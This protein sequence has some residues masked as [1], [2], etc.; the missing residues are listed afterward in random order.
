MRAAILVAVLATTPVA[1]STLLF[2][3]LTEGTWQV[4]EAD[5]AAG[6]A[7][8][9]TVTPGDKRSPAR[10][11]DGRLVFTNSNQ[12]AFMRDAKDGS[13]V[14]LLPALWPLRDLVPSTSGEQVAF[15]RIRTE[16]KDNANLAVANLD[17]SAMLQLTDV[18]GIQYNPAWSPDG[19]EI[20]FAA[21]RGPGS[22]ELFVVDA[23]GGAPRRLTQNRSL[24]FWPAW[25]PRGGR[26]AYAS[27]ATGDFEI[28][29]ADSRGGDARPIRRY[30]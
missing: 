23:D 6:T 14:P 15:A 19:T 24:E 10:L 3:R 21:G 4:W 29:M 18:A 8:Q 30:R 2:S 26:L 28:W 7:H 20:A 25:D 5:P 9:L 1:A 22:L 27:D 17:G 11:A 13:D 12:E 16:V